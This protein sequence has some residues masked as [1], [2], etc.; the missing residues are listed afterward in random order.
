MNVCR[1]YRTYH[2]KDVLAFVGL[3]V[4]CDRAEV[5]CLEGRRPLER[6]EES[7]VARTFLVSHLENEGGE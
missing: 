5:S 7:I 6:T 2:D 3:H 1:G 4:L